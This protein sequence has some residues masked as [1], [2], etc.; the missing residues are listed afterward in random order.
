M[1]SVST[2]GTPARPEATRSPQPGPLLSGLSL[3]LPH[4]RLPA[5]TLEGPVGATLTLLQCPEWASA[6]SQTALA[7]PGT[8]TDPQSRGRHHNPSAGPQVLRR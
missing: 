7:G 8:C 1:L 4:T 2:S 6:G 3:A 5:G